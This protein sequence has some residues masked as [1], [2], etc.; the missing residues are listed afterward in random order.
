MRGTYSY[1][2]LYLLHFEPRYRH[3]GHYL[4]YAKSDIRHYA[5]RVIRG[6]AMPPH[7]LVASAVVNCEEIIVAAIYPG[8]DRAERR[9]KPPAR[10]P[11]FERPIESD[12]PPMPS[13]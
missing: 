6:A 4:S 11:P 12:P 5:E 9:R 13:S 2:G 1:R 8:A 7:P 3:A 10:D